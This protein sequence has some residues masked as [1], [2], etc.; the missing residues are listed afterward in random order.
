M[1]EVTITRKIREEYKEWQNFQ[2][3]SKPTGIKKVKSEYGGGTSEEVAYETTS[4]PREITKYRE[5]ERTL[6]SQQIEDESDFD[7][8][9]V[10]AAINRINPSPK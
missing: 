9:A 1:I 7:L 10:I 2:T 4:E 8:M 5:V 6:L 3:S